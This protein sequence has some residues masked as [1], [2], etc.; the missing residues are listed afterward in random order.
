MR[1]CYLMS[2]LLVMTLLYARRAD[3]QLDVAN[4]LDIK[5]IRRVQLNDN[6]T[7]VE[8]RLTLCFVNSGLSDIR[9]RNA[10]FTLSSLIGTTNRIVLGRAIIDDCLIPARQAGDT[11]CAE[12][13]LLLRIDKNAGDFLNR[14]GALLLAFCSGHT[15]FTTGV[16][17]TCDIGMKSGSAWQ[18]AKGLEIDMEYAPRLD[19]SA[20]L[21]NA[22][23]RGIT[24]EFPSDADKK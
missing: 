19:W 5:S 16:Q 18:F 12:Q 2:V 1:I 7:N 20:M 24:I 17:G 21:E 11:I 22:G 15:N 8:A 9:V 23:H 4:S 14:M 10:D 3:A 6:G 13:D